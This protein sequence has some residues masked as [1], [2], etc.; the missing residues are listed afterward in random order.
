MTNYSNPVA[1]TAANVSKINMA[2]LWNEATSDIDYRF[3][4]KAQNVAIELVRAVNELGLTQ[5]QLATKL[6]WKPS[7]VSRI[8]HGATNVTL[9]TLFELT[10]AIGLEFDIIYRHVEQRR[11]AQ[12]W[13][14]H[15]LMVDALAICR[16]IDKLHIN[17]QENLTK[18]ELMLDTARRLN[19]R[20]WSPNKIYVPIE[21]VRCSN[22]YEVGVGSV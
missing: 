14:K 20:A 18:S 5:A 17:A 12:P 6:G 7:R 21:P 1:K 19:K 16:K 15:A 10:E 13:E 9:R 22:Q 4:I 2:E 8:L 11:A 3:E